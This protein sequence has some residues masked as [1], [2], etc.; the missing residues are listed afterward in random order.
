MS[1]FHHCGLS[2]AV[3]FAIWLAAG[4]VAAAPASAAP[5]PAGVP[6]ERATRSTPLPEG[7]FLDVQGTPRRFLPIYDQWSSRKYADPHYLRAGI[8]MLGLLGSGLVYYWVKA[9]QN[10]EDWDFPD[11]SQ[12]FTFEAVRF[13]NNLF[14]TNHILHGASGTGYYS[15]ARANGLSVPSS[16]LYSFGTS[17]VFEWGLEWLE[18]VSINDLIY[19]PMG[20]F[21][22]GEWF[23][24]LGNYLNSAP[25]G[26]GLGNQLAAATLGFPQYIH[27]R[28]DGRGLPPALPTDSLGLST[29][30]RHRFDIGYG[31]A[32][33]DNDLGRSGIEHD[34]DIEARIAS[35]PGFLRP[36]RFATDFGN[37][38][39]T[40]M[41]TRLSFDSGGWADLDLFFE[42]D[43]AGRYAQDF[44]PVPS[45]IAGDAS[46]YA[47]ASA[48]RVIDSWSLDRDD[49][50]ALAHLVGPSAKWWLAGGGALLR[51]DATASVDFAGVRSLPYR[52]WEKLYGAQ[53]TKTV[54]QK[55][56]YYYAIGTSARAGARLQYGG[57]ELGG[58]GAVGIYDSI[59]GADREQQTVT[60][61]VHNRDQMLEAE[62]WVGYTPPRTPIHFGVHGWQ[63]WR[64]SEMN[65]LS[66]SRWDRRLAI[67]LGSRF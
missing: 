65:P 50:L 61:D 67:Q 6:V 7:Y 42:A 51:L 3:A 52:Q 33:A 29:A 19:T 34:V 57:L 1:T 56:S 16:L 60:R 43:L 23:N 5:P 31:F 26:G 63:M 36:G 62:A 59:D 38:N 22:P 2:G 9:E 39:F 64:H 17:A 55:H 54:L 58:R 27:R 41:R 45:G 10:K 8:E 18:K 14:I 21:A 44:R 37:G 4:P 24:Q 12:R 30:Y 40:D 46:M 28:L 11:I 20:G 35:M 32:A 15:F 66:E 53:G 47:V 13:D 49:T 25:G 48:V